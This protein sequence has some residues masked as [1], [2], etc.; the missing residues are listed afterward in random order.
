MAVN[1]MNEIW[2]KELD[3]YYVRLDIFECIYDAIRAGKI[4]GVKI[5]E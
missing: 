2:K 5:D 1:K 4:E 3:N